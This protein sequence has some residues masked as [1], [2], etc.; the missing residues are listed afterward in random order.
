MRG[1]SG[2]IHISHSIMEFISP[3]HMDKM[4]IF[5]KIFFYN[6]ARE[7]NA[8]PLFELYTEWLAKHTRGQL[9]E[10]FAV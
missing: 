2:I 9:K 5:W 3:T 6:P 7:K 8:K 10:M 4:I 1:H